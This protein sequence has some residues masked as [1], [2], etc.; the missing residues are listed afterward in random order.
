M[1]THTHTQ[2][3]THTHTHTPPLLSSSLLQLTEAQQLG[4]TVVD[5]AASFLLS[6]TQRPQQVNPANTYIQ[7]LTFFAKIFCL[8]Q[9]HEN[10]EYSSYISC[11]GKYIS[12]FYHANSDHLT[13]QKRVTMRGVL[14]LHLSQP[15]GS[16]RDGGDSQHSH[17]VEP[18]YWWREGGGGEE[19]SNMR[20]MYSGTPHSGH[21]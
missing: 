10:Y 7:I 14:C 17:L 15:V 19:R 4:E 2:T 8:M 18:A 13:L 6:R 1:H 20:L 11:F 21:P 5:T 3:H 16:H 9:N 12:Y